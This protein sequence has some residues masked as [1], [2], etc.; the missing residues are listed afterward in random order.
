MLLTSLVP[1]VCWSLIVALT[2]L[3]PRIVVDIVALK[4]VSWSGIESGIGVVE[5][6]DEARKLDV[7]NEVGVELK[8]GLIWHNKLEIKMALELFSNGS[9]G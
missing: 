1:A 2:S 5:G 7:V 8:V 6:W 3:S 4:E 9:G